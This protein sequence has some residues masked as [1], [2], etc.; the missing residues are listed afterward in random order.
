MFFKGAYTALITPFTAKGEVDWDK[1]NELTERQIAGG[2]DGLLPVGTTGE[3]PT[4]STKEHLKVIREV[5][6]QA[7]GRCKIIAGSG[8]NST[9]E[10]IELT[11]AV[12]SF[13][14]DGTL[15]V[16]PYYN[17]PSQKGLIKHFEAVAEIG[18]PVVLYNVPGRSSREIAIST[19]A[20]LAKHPNIVSVKEAGGSVDRV[21][22]IKSVC[23]IEVLSGDDTLT[24]PMM[25]VGALGVISVASNVIPAEVGMLV[26]FALEGKWDDA[27]T[28]HYKYYKFFNDMF[29]DTNP[30]PVKSA[31]AMLGLIEETYRLPLCEMDESAKET[32]RNSLKNIGL[33]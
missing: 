1:L 13:G 14:V 9:E 12:K 27:R 18:V 26:H 23:D 20:E 2:I 30:I 32:V 7:A 25:S 16:T 8:A 19:I 3:S 28:L 10:A 22:Q 31:M 15:Q 29:V 6:R 5:T 21:S 24:L 4:L 33:L 11:E 17:K